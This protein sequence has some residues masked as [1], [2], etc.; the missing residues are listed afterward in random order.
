MGRKSGSAQPALPLAACMRVPHCGAVSAPDRVPSGGL[1]LSGGASAAAAGHWEQLPSHSTRHEL[2]GSRRGLLGRLDSA[3]VGS[4][5]SGGA[6]AM[7]CRL[8]LR[9]RA[10]RCGRRRAARLPVRS[11]FA[12]RRLRFGR[13]DRRPP[14]HRRRDAAPA[15]AAAAGDAMPSVASDAGVAVWPEAASTAACKAARTYRDS[16][17]RAF[18]MELPFTFV[19]T[20]PPIPVR[21]ASEFRFGRCGSR[22]ERSQHRALLSEHMPVLC[23]LSTKITRTY[24]GEIARSLPYSSN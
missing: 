3:V 14:P 16:G 7:R 4:T 13:I 18:K 19:S 1:S 2:A 20:A 17:A 11:A 9:T 21:A 10:S 24:C 5:R 8:W 23:P 12:R 6:A 15:A 22:L